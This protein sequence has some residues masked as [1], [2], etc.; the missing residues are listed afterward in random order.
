MKPALTATQ[1]IAIRKQYVLDNRERLNKANLERY[2]KR[3]GNL[4]TV[5][6]GVSTTTNAPTAHKFDNV[7]L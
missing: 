5:K 2:Y 6:S 3:K 7:R 1:R 4:A